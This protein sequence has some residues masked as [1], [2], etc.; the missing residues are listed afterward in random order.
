M[1]VKAAAFSI[2]DALIGFQRRLFSAGGQ[3]NGFVRRHFRRMEQVKIR[4]LKGQ[5]LFIRHARARV[6]RGVA[7][8]IQRRLHR[9]GDSLRAKIGR[10]RA[11]FTV[12]VINGDAQGAIAIEF[13]VLH[14]AVAGTNADTGSFADGDFRAVGFACRQFQR[15]GHGLF[16]RLTLL[17]NLRDDFHR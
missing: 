9:A 15:R 5:Q 4:G 8:N 14:F 12:L 7:G 2:A 11:A 6:R 3:L 17:C 16:Q 10:R 13:Y 1:A